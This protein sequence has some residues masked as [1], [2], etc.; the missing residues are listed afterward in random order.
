MNKEA[1]KRKK[2]A[3]QAD[4]FKTI[5]ERQQQMLDCINRSLEIDFPA[6]WQRKHL[7]DEFLKY[8]TNLGMRVLES[9]LGK[10]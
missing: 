5:A 8:Y 6:L 4:A 1:N 10:A 9:T 7:D 2:K 3:V